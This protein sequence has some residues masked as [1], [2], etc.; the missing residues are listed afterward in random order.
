[1]IAIR[2]TNTYTDYHFIKNRSLDIQPICFA[3]NGNWVTSAEIIKLDLHSEKS[4]QW[5]SLSTDIL[6][7]IV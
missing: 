6:D 4:Q 3:Y 2:L 5:N 1:M 7:I